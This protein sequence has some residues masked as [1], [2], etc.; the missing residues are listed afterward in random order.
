MELLISAYFHYRRE[1]QLPFL[2]GTE[3]IVVVGALFEHSS[4]ATYTVLQK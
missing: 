3:I 2:E 4:N 1:H